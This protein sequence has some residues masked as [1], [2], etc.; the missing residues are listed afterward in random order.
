M[1]IILASQSPRRHELLSTLGL[2]FTVQPGVEF[3]ES[4]V[5]EKGTG[6]LRARLQQ[7]ALIKGKDVARSNPLAV[8]VSADTVV[9][10]NKQI[11]GKP[12]D[13]VEAR[14]MLKRLSGQTHRVYTAVAVQLRHSGLEQ[15]SCEVTQVTFDVLSGDTIE[16]YIARAAPFDKAGAYAIQ[17]LGALLVQRI[18]G[19]YSNVVGLPLRLT[20]RLLASTGIEVL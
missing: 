11:L 5:L 14:T 4:T 2:E 10:I 17:G 8:V 15:A 7:L 12:R 3:D 13:V 19:E 18:D 16:R 1:D 20:A 9:E 6:D